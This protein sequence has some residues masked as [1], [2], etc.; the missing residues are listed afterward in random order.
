[1]NNEYS[2]QILALAKHLDRLDD[3]IALEDIQDGEYRAP[4][5]Y[6][7]GL[8]FEFDGEEYAVLTDDEADIAWEE[9]LQSYLDDCVYPELEGNLATYFDDEKWKRDA[10]FDGRGH[11]L[12]HYDGEEHEEKINGEWY[13]IYRTN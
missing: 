10:R 6:G 12:G 7:E 4:A 3:A 2:D 9:S 13:Y 1:M 5:L 11:A 8:L